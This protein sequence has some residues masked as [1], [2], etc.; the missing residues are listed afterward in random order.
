MGKHLS[1]GI[2]GGSEELEWMSGGTEPV[3]N[4]QYNIHL[5]VCLPIDLFIY[6]SIYLSIYSLGNYILYSILYYLYLHYVL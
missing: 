1:Q 6:L 2:E 3:E 4:E 5:S